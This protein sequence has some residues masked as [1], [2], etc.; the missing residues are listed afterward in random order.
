MRRM[1]KVQYTIPTNYNNHMKPRKRNNCLLQKLLLWNIIRHV[2][3]SAG[4]VEM[5]QPR[6]NVDRKLITPSPNPNHSCQCPSYHNP[7]DNE[8]PIT[9][10]LKRT[11]RILKLK[12]TSF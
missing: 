3:L 9:L 6:I 8:P 4:K 10:E 7:G 12:R 1:T 5:E 11:T 2:S